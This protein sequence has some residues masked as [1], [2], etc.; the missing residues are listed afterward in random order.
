MSSVHDNRKFCAQFFN[1]FDLFSY[2]NV[3]KNI[4]YTI[5]LYT[6]CNL[7]MYTFI[8]YTNIMYRQKIVYTLK[9][10]VNIIKKYQKK[11]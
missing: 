3:F 5:L 7:Y 11:K 1:K 6:V 4:P 10:G 8:L 9:K 2:I